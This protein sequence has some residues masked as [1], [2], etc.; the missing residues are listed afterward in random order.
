MNKKPT[1]AV[2]THVRFVDCD[3]AQN[4]RQALLG[5]EVLGVSLAVNGW[6][7]AQPMNSHPVNVKDTKTL[8]K[9]R[10]AKRVKLALPAEGEKNIKFKDPFTEE[11]QEFEPVQ[12]QEAYQTAYDAMTLNPD[13]GEIEE[14]THIGISGNR[15]LESLLYGNMLLTLFG[16][17]MVLEIPMITP[18]TR[19]TPQERLDVRDFENLRTGQMDPTAVEILIASRERIER[20]GSKQK[21]LRDMYGASKGVQCYYLSVIGI[22]DDKSKLGLG[23]WDKLTT[24][25]KGDKGKVTYAYPFSKFPQT[26]LQGTKTG[27]FIGPRCDVKPRFEANLKKAQAKAIQEGV[28]CTFAR[29]DAEE[30]GRLMDAAAKGEKAPKVM[31]MT[32]IGE[33][34]T[35]SCDA[36]GLVTDAIKQNDRSILDGLLTRS[37]VMNYAMDCSDESYEKLEA[38]V[39]QLIEAEAKAEVNEPVGA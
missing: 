6:D 33:L 15:R 29:P 19:Y 11:V 12:V 25:I 2:T 35:H 9:K 37:G 17:D 28:E 10:K 21:E 7:P 36:I 31:N 27:T 32:K 23:I 34:A 30:L 5:L 3:P 24:P 8:M 13:T 1:T 14:P 38:F 39:D 16:Y 18:E 4:I 20:Y 26:M 22:F